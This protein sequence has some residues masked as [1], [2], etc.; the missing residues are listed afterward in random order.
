MI[1]PVDP[2]LAP[3]ASAS[4]TIGVFDGVHRGHRALVDRVCEG[5]ARLGGESVAVT[6]DPHPAAILA[7]E[8]EPP[9][10]TDTLEKVERLREAGVARVVV[11]PFSIELAALSPEEFVDRHLLSQVNLAELI[12]GP[13]F[14]LGH[15]RVGDA[16][17]LAAIGSSRGFVVEVVPARLDGVEVISSSRIRRLVQ[18]GDIV[19][20]AGLLGRPYRVAGRV[21]RGDGRGR[22]LGIPT[23]NLDVARGCCRPAA[24]VYA[25]RIRTGS[26]FPEAG[27][28]G[29]MNVGIRPTF[30]GV[31]LRFEVH[32]FD[33]EGDALDEWWEIDLIERL[34]EERRFDSPAELAGQ[35]QADI[36]RSRELLSR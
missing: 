34:R 3:R 31:G 33:W 23:A 29:V 27:H 9:Y 14:A 5:A 21:I 35:I 32:R 18:R 6:F 12:I 28:A 2:C 16:R 30:D 19:L 24:G 7:P 25:V 15:G 4:V 17:R 11:L 22:Q 10:L 26:G 36:V 1:D 8:H 20:A 13:D